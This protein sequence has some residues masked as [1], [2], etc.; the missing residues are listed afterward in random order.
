MT[1]TAVK[2]TWKIDTAHS[3]IHFKVKHMMVSTVTGAFGKFDATV[4]ADGD[5]FEDAEIRFS[6]DVDSIN[7]NNEQRD[8]HL[9]SDD[10]FNA[11]KFPQ[12]TFQSTSFDK[13]ADGT[14]QLKGD[15]TIRDI[16]KP[17]TLDV[18]YNGT[19][20]DP[21][22]NTKAGFEITGKINRKEFGLKWSAITEAGSVVVGDDVRLVLNVQLTKV[23]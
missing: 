3:E 12:L 21:Y 13:Q 2:T 5:D 18:E 10:F 16:T 14:Y 9:K 4:D 8:A 20:V 6:A 23:A 1:N 11:E 7:T 15:L 19:A 22:G 17:V